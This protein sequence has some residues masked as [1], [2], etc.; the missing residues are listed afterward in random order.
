MPPSFLFFQSIVQ[1]RIP[2]NEDGTLGNPEI[3]NKF[4]TAVKG[5]K[6]YNKK[7]PKKIEL[8]AEDGGTID[9]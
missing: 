8:E 3:T 5:A 9:L 1:Y 6:E 2:L 4:T 7:K